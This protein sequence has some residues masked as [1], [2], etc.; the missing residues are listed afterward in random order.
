MP[1]RTLNNYLMIPVPMQFTFNNTFSR[2]SPVFYRKV[3]PQ[4]LENP[5]LVSFNANAAK[6]IDQDH[7]FALD[8]DFINVF[9]GKLVPEGAVPISMVY[10][11]HQFGVYVP[12]LGDGR[13]HLLGEVVNKKNE[14]WDVQLKGSGLTPFSRSG[15]GRAVLRST[16]R[17]YL[18]SEA[19]HGL[20][21]PTTR[22]LCIIGSSQR[23]YREQVET[24]AILTRLSPSHIRFG[25]FEYFF[26][27]RQPEALQ[28]LAD[29]VIEQHYS[30]FEQA[31]DKYIL[32]FDEVVRL[33]ANLIAQWQAVGFSH[34]VMNSDNMSILGLTLDYGPYGFM[35]EFD[36]GYI[37]NHSDI[38]GR[39]AFG[40]QPIIGLFNLNCLAH[41][42]S[43]LI[44]IDSLRASLSTY[45]DTYLKEYHRLMCLKLGLQNP[46][47]GDEEIVDELL[48]L[49][50]MNKVDYTLFFRGLSTMDIDRKYPD[51]DS[52]FADQAGFYNWLTTY[53]NR[54]LAENTNGT[55][56]KKL[57]GNHNPVYIL[58]NYMA[59]QAIELAEKGDFSEVDRLLELLSD[60][61]TEKKGAGEY[62]K[63]SPEW[64]KQLVVSCSS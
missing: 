47:P 44:D 43:E 2:L 13:A 35:E 40:N 6:L 62:A 53:K 9:S 48:S 32:L 39:Y 11:G 27:T 16:I 12:Q 5:H 21:I 8:E 55:H 59:Q 23:V 54:L 52:L 46:L 29:Y 50:H 3:L 14:K 26:H 56:R 60:P 1:S 22:A 63:P 25:S 49:L 28:R 10:S 19:M 34:G 4:G 61:F 58:R 51:F 38:E 42:F 64:G 24:G 57:M 18:C 45:Q 30:S 7:T 41:A 20:G 37:C 17:E 15:D 36:P 31:S 33:T